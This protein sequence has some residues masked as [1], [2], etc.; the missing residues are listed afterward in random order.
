MGSSTS[1]AAQ[2][3]ARKYPIRAPGSSLPSAPRAKIAP[4]DVSKRLGDG[5]KDEAVRA[6]AM[7]PD[8]VTG[9]FSRRL[10]QMGIAQPN[11]TYS[12]SST[13][14]SHLGPHAPIAPSSFPSARGNRTLSALDARQRLQQEAD[15]DLEAIGRTGAQGR[16]FL[17]MRTVV[18]AIKLRD[19][20]QSPREIEIKLRI[21]P[22]LLDKLGRQGILS[23]VTSPS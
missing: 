6:D 1:K 22:G 9:D 10:H 17:D 5:P 23:H 15:N 19:H 13:A 11:P 2:G 14:S 21:Q 20:G 7:D 4:N 8:S 3:A 16:R 18:D 12:P